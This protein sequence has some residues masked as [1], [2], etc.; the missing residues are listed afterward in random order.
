M[1]T[2]GW[3]ASLPPE[4]VVVPVESKRYEQILAEIA[5]LLYNHWASSPNLNPKATSRPDE[6]RTPPAAHVAAERGMNHE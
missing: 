2:R 1:T 5:E 6:F 3:N 4:K